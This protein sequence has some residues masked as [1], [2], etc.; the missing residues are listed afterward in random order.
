[1][2]RISSCAWFVTSISTSVVSALLSLEPVLDFDDSEDDMI[3]QSTQFKPKYSIIYLSDWS[4]LAQGCFVY[5]NS[6][7]CKFTSY[8]IDVT[9]LI[10]HQ[11]GCGGKNRNL[12][13]KNKG[14]MKFLS[15]NINCK[16][17]QNR[18]KYTN[19]Q[20]PKKCDRHFNHHFRNPESKC[21]L[22][23]ELPLLCN[24]FL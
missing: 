24:T 21:C 3:P 7:L 16:V 22:Y 14:K 2:V 23:L 12:I 6:A 8:P 1:M 11:Y 20:K 10:S 17:A 18:R 15:M 5:C 13:A 19:M 9:A 4:L